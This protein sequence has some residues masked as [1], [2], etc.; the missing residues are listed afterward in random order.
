MAPTSIVW[1]MFGM[2]QGDGQ[3]RL[4]REQLDVLGRPRQLREQPLDGDLGAGPGPIQGSRPNDLRH[5]ALS[6]R[7]E[8]FVVAETRARRPE[9]D[10]GLLHRRRS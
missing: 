10:L 6:E 8:D 2:S 5:A 4:A 3:L 7:R 9:Y 1:T